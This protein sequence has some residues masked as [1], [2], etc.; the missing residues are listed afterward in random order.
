M[1]ALL[2]NGRHLDWSSRDDA[3]LYHVTFTAN[4][5]ANYVLVNGEVVSQCACVCACVCVRARVVCVCVC[6]YP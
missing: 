6:V 5:S 2:A 1:V 3:Y 4:W